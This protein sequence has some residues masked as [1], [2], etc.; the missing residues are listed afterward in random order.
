MWARSAKPPQLV[1]KTNEVEAIYSSGCQ[2]NKVS[3]YN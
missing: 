2:N 3:G 1:M